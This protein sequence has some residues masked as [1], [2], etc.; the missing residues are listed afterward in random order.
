MKR[1]WTTFDANHI[2]EII[3]EL[4]S[5][6]DDTS[7]SLTYYTYMGFIAKMRTW[8]FSK[9]A[10]YF[11]KPMT[12]EENESASR[13]VKV[14]NEDRTDY[15]YEWKGSETEG[16]L[17]TVYSMAQQFHEHKMD[18]IKNG[19]LNEK[20]KKNLSMLMGIS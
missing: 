10:R 12:A 16:I 19:S 17:Y 5:S 4:Y 18:V 6:L 20:Q 1:A 3:V 2:K 14:M 9:T 15:R 8:L 11:A 7:K 13:L